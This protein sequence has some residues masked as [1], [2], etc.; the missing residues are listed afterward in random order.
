MVNDRPKAPTKTPAKAPAMRRQ[1]K[2]TR[3][4]ERVHHILDVAEQLFIESGYEQATTREIASRAG[5][6]IGSLYQFFPDKAAIVRALANRYFAQEYQMFVQLHAELAEAELTTY[7]DRM[8]DAFAQF[9]DDHPGYRAVLRQLLDQMTVAD[10]SVPNEYDQLMLE[11]LAHFL[12][13]RN[14]GLDRDRSQLIATIVF[15]AANELLW[16]AFSRESQER[17]AVIAE[18]K[19]LITAYL[20]TFG[21]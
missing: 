11:G 20:K 16:M 3:S 19:V 2:Q 17:S 8:I 5:V 1:P 10:A 9:A 6:A 12:A 7:V 14:A 4:Q 13:Q 15:K 21:I 18:T